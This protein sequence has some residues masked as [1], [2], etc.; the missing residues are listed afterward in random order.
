MAR[1]RKP[2]V[3]YHKF[4]KAS[5]AGNKIAGRGRLSEIDGALVVWRKHRIRS[6]YEDRQRMLFAILHACKRFLSGDGNTWVDPI[7]GT[8]LGAGRTQAVNELKQAVAKRIAWENFEVNRKKGKRFQTKSLDGVH[9]FEKRVADARKGQA[10][11]G[12]T[13]I[14][15]VLQ[16]MRNDGQT[17][18]ELDDL[19]WDLYQSIEAQLVNNQ[20]PAWSHGLH[21]QYYDREE[22]VGHLLIPHDGKFWT[23]AGDLYDTSAH[24]WNKVAYAV[25]HYGNFYAGPGNP[26]VI[27]HSTF[28]R[29]KPIVCAG[30]I[31]V[32]NGNVT[33][34]SNGSGHYKPDLNQLKTALKI[35]RSNGFTLLN[36]TMLDLA[37]GN[38]QPALAFLAMD[39]VNFIYRAA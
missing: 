1:L 9:A 25:D 8:A 33:W 18:K 3:S 22:R 38:E 12:A 2:D 23:S 34:I 39:G 4:Q 13:L 6:S 15:E 27:N 11:A 21:L 36:T 26:G 7:T 32:L 35:L 37:S 29:G 17:D 28:C 14:G 16:N 5:S 31:I 10:M 20:G 19:D 24:P 30:E